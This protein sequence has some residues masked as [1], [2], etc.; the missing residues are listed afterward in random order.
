MPDQP[1]QPTPGDSPLVWEI[2]VP[3]LN[4]RA[5]MSGV[6][7]GFGFAGLIMSA[8]LGFLFAMQREWE[9]ILP[10]LAMT[11]G[12]CLVL[13]LVGLASM[14]VVFRNRMR[15]RYTLSSD[16]VLMETVDAT[17]KVVNRLTLAA[18]VLGG[19]PGTAGTG[20]IATSNE[21]QAITWDGAFK[22]RF[23]DR[24]RMV[25]MRNAWRTIFYVYCTAENYAEVSSAIRAEMTA[26]GTES[27]VTGR[28]PVP[29][30]LLRTALV[31][32]ACVPSFALV[33]AFDVSLLI[34]LILLCFALAM[35]WLIGIFGWV[36]LITMAVEAAV[37]VMNALSVRESFFD[38]GETYLRYTVFSGD[39]WALIVVTALSFLL[40]GWMA[41][42]SIRGRTPSVL[43]SDYEDMGD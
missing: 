36:V 25:A 1:T 41:I 29:G 5:V 8:L 18:G 23:N 10:M 24:T 39:D 34:P 15:F 33:E 14:A 3:L 11:W 6:A 40:L 2:A 7:K 32:V 22:A 37:V 20:L 17:V 4:N 35:V 26:H 27:R 12:I 21:S 42:R 28:S 9:A 38:P 30:F 31:I 19:S 43:S 16:G 13:Y